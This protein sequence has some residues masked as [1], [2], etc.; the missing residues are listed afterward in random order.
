MFYEDAFSKEITS[1]KWSLLV[2]DKKTYGLGIKAGRISELLAQVVES[3]LHFPMSLCRFI[4]QLL[5]DHRLDELP[6]RY[7]G[8]R[9]ALAVFVLNHQEGFPNRVLIDAEKL[10]PKS[11][12]PGKPGRPKLVKA[13]APKSKKKE[14]KKKKTPKTKVSTSE[15]S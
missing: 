9:K 8:D 6:F 1:E 2:R 15:I 4:A 3:R 7:E 5:L 10:A 14:L 12:K 11:K 13:L